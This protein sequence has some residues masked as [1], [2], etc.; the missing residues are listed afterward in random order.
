[1]LPFLQIDQEDSS[2]YFTDAH[3]IVNL[4]LEKISYKFERNKSPRR[5][6]N[7]HSS[8]DGDV[9]G[10]V[11]KEKRFFSFSRLVFFLFKC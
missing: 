5:Y 1:M 7:I 6:F 3:R 10:F 9:I 2:I 4:E 8:V 11:K